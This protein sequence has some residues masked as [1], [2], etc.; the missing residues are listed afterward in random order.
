MNYNLS[1]FR[2]AQEQDYET[3][4]SEIRAGHKSSHWIWYI[5]TI[6]GYELHDI[7]RFVFRE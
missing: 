3:A 1:R 6:G 5:G 2:K 4:L 7:L